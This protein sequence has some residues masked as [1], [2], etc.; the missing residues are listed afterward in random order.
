[1]VRI[2]RGGVTLEQGDVSMQA[3]PPAKSVQREV[4]VEDIFVHPESSLSYV[5]L[6]PWYFE[7]C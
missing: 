6:Q 3:C 1:M 7:L 4:Y 5:L 2:L